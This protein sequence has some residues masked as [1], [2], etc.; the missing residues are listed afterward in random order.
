MRIGIVNDMALAREALRRVVLSAPGQQVA[1]LAADGDE[2]V[3]Q[4]RRDTPDLILM[5][6]I[7]PVT[8]GAEATRRIMAESPC[9]IIVVTSSV[10]GNFGKVYEAMGHGA[11]DA[12]DT[13][14]LGPRGDVQGAE[15][16]LTKIMTVAKLTGKAAARPVPAPSPAPSPA[17][18]TPDQ[19][20]VVIGASTG[21]PNAVAEV[22]SSFPKGWYASV[23]LIQHVDAAFAPGLARWLTERSGNRVEIAAAGARP[24]PGQIL[25]A[26]TNDHLVMESGGRFRYISEPR[27]FCFRPSVDVFFTSVAAHWPATGVAALLTGMLRD[28]AD[29]L[30]TLRRAGWFTIAQDK[31]S[32]VVWGM[33]RAAIEVGAAVAVLPVSRIGPAVV[34]RVTNRARTDEVP[35]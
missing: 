9:P 15:A 32:S 7:M 14:T 1:W 33:P 26:A 11:L 22:L 2:A 18:A 31:E 28:G 6:L 35:R 23:V 30:L 27:D 16:L 25:L 29:G 3:A 4:A 24:A 13:P 12:V 21:G 34:D 10:S 20:L 5:D 8:D 17:A 19:S